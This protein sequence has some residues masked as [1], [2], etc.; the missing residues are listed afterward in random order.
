MH[1]SRPAVPPGA[2][3][4]S[5]RAPRAILHKPHFQVA[6]DRRRCPCVTRLL[7]Q[8]PNRQIMVEPGRR[9]FPSPGPLPTAAAAQ[10]ISVRLASALPAAAF[11]FL[12]AVDT[13]AVR[14]AV[15]LARPVADFH[16]QVIRPSPQVPEQRRSGRCP[17][18]VG[19]QQ[20]S[21][22]IRRCGRFFVLPQARS[23]NRPS[24][25]H[26]PQ[27]RARPWG[28]GTCVPGARLPPGHP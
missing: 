23:V 12:L 16:R 8:F 28:R 22:R 2:S 3:P 11:G 9:S 15:P 21:A 20:K 25:V 5:D 17:P 19:R 26:R 24:G 27:E 13:L 6:P 1:V 7:H 10:A 14:L 18:G 4:I